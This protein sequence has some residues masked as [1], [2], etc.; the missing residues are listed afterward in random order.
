M[1]G[2]V[3][4]VVGIDVER[5]DKTLTI[6][7]MKRRSR[8]TSNGPE[9]KRRASEAFKHSMLLPEAAAGDALEAKYRKGVLKV[10]VPRSHVAHSR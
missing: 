5:R 8:K 9:S 10:H 4:R 7:G 3:L 1:P 6:R 2:D